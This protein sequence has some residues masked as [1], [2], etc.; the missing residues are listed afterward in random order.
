MYKVKGGVVHLQGDDIGNFAGLDEGCLCIKA[1]TG[2]LW[3]GRDSIP[4]LCIEV[5]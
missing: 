4:D 1:Y 5:I 3:E 2:I